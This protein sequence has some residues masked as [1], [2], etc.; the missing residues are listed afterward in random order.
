MTYNY[1]RILPGSFINMIKENV[2]SAKKKNVSNGLSNLNTVQALE[3]FLK[4]LRQGHSDEIVQL[5]LKDQA[6]NLFPKGGDTL[7]WLTNKIGKKA[8][9]KTVVAF[10]RLV[11]FNCKD[12]LRSC[13]NCNATGHFDYEMVCESC[14]GLTKAPCDF[15]G[16]TGW[17]SIDCIPLGLRMAVFGVHIENAEKQIINMLEKE[18]PY[19]SNEN[20]EV[21]FD[22][23]VR[24]N[25]EVIFDKC[26]RLLFQLNRQISVLESTVGVTQNMIEVPNNFK[27]QMSK[28][29]RKCVLIALKGEK[30][31][32]E[33]IKTM[34]ETFKLQSER[35]EK[36][37][38]MQKFAAARTKFYTGLLDTRPPFAG[39]YLEHPFLNEAAKKLVPNK[40]MNKRTQDDNEA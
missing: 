20:V 7:K 23:C 9:T 21:I 4:M 27:K 28:I 40:D 30:R 12:G 24:E 32:G 6:H 33:I 19:L 39:T 11:C 1:K 36:G 18:L 34:K 13:E 14:L 26:V 35:E 16:G 37:S 31:L 25:V 5:F 8:T 22:K 3:S 10:A 15:C 38:K 17:V 2:N 29:T